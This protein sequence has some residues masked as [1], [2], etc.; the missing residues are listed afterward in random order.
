MSRKWLWFYIIIS[1]FFSQII[2]S[3]DLFSMDRKPDETPRTEAPK[4]VEVPAL[5]PEQ[6]DQPG[7][8]SSQK[9]AQSRAHGDIFSRLQQI[10]DFKN[11]ERFVK[12][13][14]NEGF[15]VVSSGDIT[16]DKETIYTLFAEKPKE[17]S[18]DALSSGEIKHETT[19][20]MPYLEDKPIGRGRIS[21]DIFGRKGGYVHPFLSITEYY[22]D[23]VFNA[24]V[25]K[26]SDF[27]TVISPGI[28]LT[29]PHIYEKLLDINTSSMAPGGFTL[30][31]FKPEFF[32]RYQT[33]L[34]YGADIERFSK[35]SSEDV[36][37]HN[38][39]GLFQYNLKGGISIELVDKFLASHDIRG[40]G[41]SAK[42]DKYR[43]NLSNLILTYDV[44]KKIKFRIDYSNFLVN[45]VES[46]NNFRN[47][48]DNAFSGYIFYKFQPK[49]S[50]FVEYEFVD[51]NYKENILF[52]SRE[53][54]YFGGLQ[55]DITAKS[56]GSVKAGYGIKDFSGSAIG[57]S[58]G[59]ILEVQIDHKFTPKTS[60]IVKASRKTNETNMLTTSYL[61]SNSIEAEYIQRLTGKITGEVNLSY[62][63]DNYKGDLTFGG[64]TKER[65]DDLF[66]GALA[67]QYK[68]KKWLNMDT[69]Y[70]YMQRDSNFSDFDYTSNSIFIRITTS[71]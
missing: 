2:P 41:L 10:V 66:K 47:R 45:Y 38:V 24:N 51:I 12:K 52:N 15:K 69:G 34:F 62:T 50:V 46:R 35:Y 42:L 71:L 40:T 13:L 14:R 27:L 65:K 37:V 25:D 31:R 56:K 18:K 55:W 44:H 39:E 53:H 21:G 3:A 33:Y 63:N 23:N 60:L 57:N 49:T 19:S 30:S 9:K 7:S 20:E 28:W 22:T 4:P 5:S 64:E 36:T 54:H 43:T 16:K 67:L 1:I 26:K 29:V 58:E 17:L 59:F 32:R 8:F 61:L 48:T 11:A 68:F 70:I 6:P